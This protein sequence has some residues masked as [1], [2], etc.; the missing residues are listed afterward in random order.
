LLANGSGTRTPAAADVAPE[1][2]TDGSDDLLRTYEAEIEG[3]RGE[4]DDAL[5]K[6]E[7]VTAS[8][9]WRLT[10]PLRGAAMLMRRLRRA[11]R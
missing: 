7:S 8:R 2:D 10:A 1:A 11:R 3:L 6:Y 5:Q 4:R 9:S